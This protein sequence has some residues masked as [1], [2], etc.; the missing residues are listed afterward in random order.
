MSHLKY[1]PHGFAELSTDNFI[2]IIIKNARNHAA[3][4]GAQHVAGALKK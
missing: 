4:R 2:I 3:E 1:Q